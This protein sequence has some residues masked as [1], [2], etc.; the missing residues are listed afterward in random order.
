MD[1]SY[2]TLKNLTYKYPGNHNITLNNI[3][4]NIERGDIVLVCGNS[5]SG[6]ST[7]GKCITGSVPNFYGGTIRGEIKINDK[8]IKDLAPKE[9]AEKV[10]MVFQDPERQLLMNKVHREIAF[11]LENIGVK[12]EV[13][14][15]R[16]YESMEF[17]GIE[18]LAK[19]DIIS[20]SGGEKQKVAVTSALAYMPECIILDEPTSQLDPNAAEEVINIINKINEELGVT[21]ILIEQRVE[22]CFSI[23]DKVLLINDGTVSFYGG[24]DDLYKSNDPYFFDFMPQYL[25][26]SKILKFSKMPCGI[27]ETRKKLNSFN[28]TQHNSVE[29]KCDSQEPIINISDLC[30]SY[31]GNANVLKNINLNINSGEFVEIMG[32]NGAGKSTFF[33]SIMGFTKYKGSIKLFGKEVSKY[34]QRDLAKIIG[35]ISQNPNDYISK[36]TVYEEVKFTL[37]NYGIKNYELIDATLNKLGIDNLKY[38]NPRDISGGE[39]QRV[40]IASILVMEP[41]II[42]L[43]EPTRGLDHKTKELLGNTLKDLNKKGSTIIMITHDI[44]FAAEFANKFILLFNGEAI[45]AGTKTEVFTGG[46]YYNTS[47]N[48]LFRNID[49]DIFTIDDVLERVNLVKG[50][51]YE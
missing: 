49:N 13:I 38:K 36:E 46:T 12:P 42:L 17:C 31:D 32:P 43:D 2:I 34:K 41:E 27:R 28:I 21:I 23:A 16:V 50:G 19:R 4:I 48:K 15:R 35:Y 51:L 26:L 11:G 3:N 47:M 33:K 29:K 5:G 45:Q 44:E 9:L 37:D 6:K 40:A 20:L 10:T 18:K 8:N 22:K 39:K 30:F 7:L 1:M 24:K 25:K 14:K